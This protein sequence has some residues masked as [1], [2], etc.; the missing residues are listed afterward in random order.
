MGINDIGITWGLVGMQALGLLPRPTEARAALEQ[1]RQVN[2]ISY[3]GFDADGSG[4]LE[5]DF[6]WLGSLPPLCLRILQAFW[7]MQDSW[8]LMVM[9][10]SVSMSLSSGTGPLLCP[11]G[12]SHQCEVA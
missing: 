8:V 2:V 6:T 5:G 3:L 10:A 11:S 1:D 9:A 4:S 7:P 12:S